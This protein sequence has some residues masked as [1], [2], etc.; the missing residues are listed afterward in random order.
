VPS[1][2]FWTDEAITALRVSGATTAQFVAA[3]DDGRPHSVAQLRQTL[4]LERAGSL[5]RVLASLASED[6]QHP[7]VYYLLANLSTRAFGFSIAD[8]RLPALICGLLLPFGLAWLC[9]ELFGNIAAMVAGFAIGAASPVLAVY[10]LQA[11]EYSAWA[12]VLTLLT[13]VFLRASRTSGAGWWLAYCLLAIVALYTDVLAAVTIIAHAAFALVLLRGRRLA[14][15]AGSALCAAA[16]YA[17]WLVQIAVHRSAIA[18]ENGWTA[19]PWPLWML[20]EKWAFNGG[21]TFWDYEFARAGAAVLLIPIALVLCA[22]IIWS[23][24]SSP[25]RARVMLAAAIAVPIA[26]LFLPDVV[27]HHHRSSVTRYGIP[28]WIAFIACTAGYL[29]SRLRLHAGRLHAG[30]TAVTV[31]FVCACVF[32]AS[33]ASLSP[34]WWD[35]RQDGDLPAIALAIENSAAPLVVVNAPWPR[36]LDLSFYL[37]PDV[38]M[39]IGG[40]IPPA[41]ADARPVFVLAHDAPRGERVEVVY[42]AR[43]NAQAARLRGSGD[44]DSLTLW[45][46]V[47]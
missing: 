19:G 12:L 46:V 20:V 32:S 21:T 18:R 1:R 43:Q 22:A 31:L 17:P 47:R 3:A 26:L 34:V 11:R 13:A 7:P 39:Q 15:C 25:A 33:A 23:L 14:Y 2:A 16:A 37:Q 6:A 10:S 30:W 29:G 5:R 4:G 27:A 9:R 45:R 41:Q 42:Q 40:K 35:N 44:P 38:R 28:L 24:R 36:A 8:L